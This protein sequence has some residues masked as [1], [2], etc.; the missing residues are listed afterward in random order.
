MKNFR[1]LVL[2]ETETVTHAYI[3]ST[4]DF[5]QITT[6]TSTTAVVDVESWG[7]YITVA[8][9]LPDFNVKPSGTQTVTTGFLAH[10]LSLLVKRREDVITGKPE[11]LHTFLIKCKTICDRFL[12]KKIVKKSEKS[13]F[14]VT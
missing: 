8:C 10:S 4:R 1:L 14:I 9:R 7:E 3:A 6:A 11:T 5:K 13:S 12:K 2:S